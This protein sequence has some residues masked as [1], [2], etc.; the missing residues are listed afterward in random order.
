MSVTVWVGQDGMLSDDN[1]IGRDVK[2]DLV[3]HCINIINYEIKFFKTNK[4][5]S[6]CETGNGLITRIL[7]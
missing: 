5:R 7:F 6:K 2:H 3:L 1:K 4:S